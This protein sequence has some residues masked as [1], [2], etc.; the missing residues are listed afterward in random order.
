MDDYPT[1]PQTIRTQLRPR[2]GKIVRTASNGATRIR[3]TQAADKFDISFDHGVITEAQR[4]T[5][6][7]WYAAHRSVAFYCI[8][9]EDGVQRTVYFAAQ[10]YVIEPLGGSQFHLQVNLVQA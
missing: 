1:L 7:T 4:Q 3:D 8:P 6:L 10:P 2:T 5:F 9:V